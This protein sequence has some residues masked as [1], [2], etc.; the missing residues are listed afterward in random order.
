MIMSIGYAELFNRKCSIISAFRCMVFIGK[1]SE[2]IKSVYI[3]RVENY[4]ETSFL[5]SEIPKAK[6][7]R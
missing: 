5:Q 1:Y 2:K 4:L 7:R 6:T 3:D